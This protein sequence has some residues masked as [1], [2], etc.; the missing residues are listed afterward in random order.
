MDGAGPREPAKAAAACRTAERSSSV[1]VR[2]TPRNAVRRRSKTSVTSSTADAVAAIT[3][4]L[5]FSIVLLLTC[6]STVI[7]FTRERRAYDRAERALLLERVGEYY[8]LEVDA[9]TKVPTADARENQAALAAMG[10]KGLRLHGDDDWRQFAKAKFEQHLATTKRPDQ[11]LD[12]VEPE[13]SGLLLDVCC[14]L[15]G[16]EDV[17]RERQWPLRSAKIVLRLGLDRLARHYGYAAQAT[18]P[19]RAAVRT[20]L[21]DEEELKVG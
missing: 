10:G 13:F 4:A 3:T 12:A 15:K 2:N 17:E 20:W 7:A 8:G 19:A 11:A 14:F 6:W 21:D 1:I 18:G 9:A 5:P 16:L